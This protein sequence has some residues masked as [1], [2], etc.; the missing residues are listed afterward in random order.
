[1]DLSSKLVTEVARASVGEAEKPSP[2]TVYGTVASYDGKPYVRL[3]GSDQLTPVET[4]AMLK[5]GDRV[6]VTIGGHRA[7]VGGNVSSPSAGKGDID[8]AKKELGNK[9]SQ[10][11]ILIAD[12]VDTD[13]LNAANARIDELVSDNV[14]IKDTLTAHKAEIDEVAADN[15]TVK[16]TLAANKAEIDGL[17]VSSLTAEKADL[18]Y[19]TIESLEATDANIHNLEADYGEFKQLSTDRFAANDAEIKRLDTEKLSAEQADLKY[20]NI[21]FANIGKAAIENFLSKSGMV[22]DLVVGEGTVTGT[23]VGVT[24]KGDLIEGGTVVA[25]KLVIKGDD[26]LF[27]KLNTDGVSTSA[28]QTEYNSLSGSVITAKSITAEKVSVSDLVAFGATIGG[29]TITQDALYSGAKESVGNTT[30]GTYMDDTGQFAIGDQSNYLRFFRDEKDGRW[31]LELSAASIKMGSSSQD[32]G[33]YIDQKVDDKTAD[34]DALQGS[35]VDYQAGPD[36]ASPPSGEW[37][38]TIPGVEPGQFL[39]TRTTM[40]YTSGKTVVSYSV[41]RQGADGANG[42]DAVTLQ[43]LSSNGNLFKNSMVATTLTVTIIVAGEMVTSSAQMH[44]RFGPG[45]S[46]RWEQKRFQ[47]TEYSP[48]DPSDARLS[49]EGFILEL[50]ASDVWTQTAFNCYLDY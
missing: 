34:I 28:E 21:D 26:G 10:V 18:R 23:L 27:Y 9:I 17:R 6:R 15:V 30:R 49:D 43:I 48:I 35:K 40:T 11:E 38:E 12:K 36:G 13:E 7:T 8:D 25:D 24:I 39:W 50:Q 5:A 20:A 22:G 45:A 19:A 33:E 44:E 31:K 46:L 1:M 42:K 37:S 2:K 14:T 3:D 32:I 29:F 41:S 16:E 4:T 47:E